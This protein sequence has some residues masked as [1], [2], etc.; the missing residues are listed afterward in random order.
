MKAFS[1]RFVR[2]FVLLLALSLLLGTVGCGTSADS[3]ESAEPSS[4]ENSEM[5]QESSEQSVEESNPEDD[6]AYIYSLYTQTVEYGLDQLDFPEYAIYRAYIY[7]DQGKLI[8]SAQYKYTKRYGDK[9]QHNYL[10]TL[11]FYDENERAYQSLVFNLY[12]EV[13]QTHTFEYNDAG[14]MV[15]RY[16]VTPLGNE[17]FYDYEYDSL[18]QLTK[19]ERYSMENGSKNVFYS[20][21]V[22][23]DSYGKPSKIQLKEHGLKSSYFDTQYDDSKPLSAKVYK[24][25]SLKNLDYSVNYHYDGGTLLYAYNQSTEVD[26]NG[27]PLVWLEF[28]P[29]SGGFD[30]SVSDNYYKDHV[31]ENIE[32]SFDEEHDVNRI[33]FKAKRS[34]TNELYTLAYREYFENQPLTRKDF[35]LYQI[36]T[37]DEINELKIKEPF[38]MEEST[39]EEEIVRPEATEIEITLANYQDYFEIVPSTV[40]YI[41][42][43]YND[44]E[45]FYPYGLT[46]SLNEDYIQSY[47]LNA[48]YYIPEH[49]SGFV[50]YELEEISYLLLQNEISFEPVGH[51]ECTLQLTIEDPDAAKLFGWSEKTVTCKIGS[52]EYAKFLMDYTDVI[53]NTWEDMFPSIFAEIYSAGLLRSSV[54]NSSFGP[55]EKGDSSL[56]QDYIKVEVVEI[57]GTLP[58]YQ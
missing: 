57:S 55:Q 28:S 52:Y 41:R 34:D 20:K 48:N 36:L 40:C 15:H 45:L 25:Q 58:V 5:S 19:E 11:T 32:F 18:G 38:E 13:I 9:P 26:E 2:F 7:D 37:I 53:D 29:M 16:I 33:E 14:L 35:Y 50:G 44:T 47:L 22:E 27:R 17:T 6:P 8:R 54:D 39:V 4:S 30:F 12:R 51:I 31:V 1:H 46:L 56:I 23:Y 3:S 49:S 24:D 21:T 10:E 43:E 42:E